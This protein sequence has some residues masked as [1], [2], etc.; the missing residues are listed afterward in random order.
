MNEQ[1]TPPK[2]KA[3][4]FD[5]GETLFDST[6]VTPDLIKDRARQSFLQVHEYLCS[7]GKPLPPQAEFFKAL[8]SLLNARLEE[9]NVTLRSVHIGPVLQ[10]LLGRMEI[11]LTHEELR[12]CVWRTYEYNE[13]MAVLYPEA[14][15]L[16]NQLRAAGLQVGLIS[17]SIWPHWCHDVTLA[18]LGVRDLLYPR[19]Y[20]ADWEYKK[21]HASIFKQALDMLDVSPNAAVFVGDHLDPDVLGAQGA[22]MKA[23]LLEVPYRQENHPAIRPDERISRLAE[24]PRALDRLFGSQWR[25]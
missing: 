14:L 8:A 7:L 22:G 9:S 18:K 10:E 12:E 21:P 24:L 20:S 2:L 13:G 5:L 25:T 19:L 15:P 4:I 16:I 1:P 11:A 17:N 6:G 23:V 3:V